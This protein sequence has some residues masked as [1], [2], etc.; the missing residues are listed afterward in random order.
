VLGQ[1]TSLDDEWKVNCRDPGKIKEDEEGKLGPKA[2]LS[3]DI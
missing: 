3:A 1:T 2:V